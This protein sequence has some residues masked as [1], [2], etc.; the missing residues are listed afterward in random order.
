MASFRSWFER[1]M[2]ES[3]AFS[4]PDRFDPEQLA[5]GP[6]TVILDNLA[7]PPE[8][9]SARTRHAA[10][11]SF[12]RTP[13]VFRASSEESSGATGLLTTAQR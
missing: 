8:R 10:G 1:T 6:A 4:R 12:A 3:T 9:L 13:S 11:V 5:V 2:T 7:F